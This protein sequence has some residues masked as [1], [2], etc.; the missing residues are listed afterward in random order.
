MEENEKSKFKIVT[1]S[2]GDIFASAAGGAA[3]GTALGGPAGFVIG[4]VSGVCAT[5]VASSIKPHISFP[6]HK[7]IKSKVDAEDDT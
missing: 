4:A 7:V 1:A 3:L 2:T 5:V 6:T